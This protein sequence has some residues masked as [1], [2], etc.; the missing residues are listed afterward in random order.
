M[1][2][3]TY[4]KEIIDII[5]NLNSESYLVQLATGLGTTVTF[6]NIKRKGRV[7]VLAHREELVIQ[8]I[9]YYDLSVG[10]EMR[11]LKSNGEVVVIVSVQSL[12]RRLNRFNKNDF[13]MIITDECH[14]SIAKSYRKIYEYF[15]NRLHISF[16]VTPNR[17][18]GKSID[19]IFDEYIEKNEDNVLFEDYLK[20]RDVLVG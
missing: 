10:I 2:F 4:Q 1:E 18:D 13:D 8:P 19:G 12:V 11:E 16:T 20:V 14:H 9:K 15:N 17:G 6:A 7:L 5:D 3:R